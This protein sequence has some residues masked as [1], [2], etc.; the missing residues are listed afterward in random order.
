[1]S[2]TITLSHR[3]MIENNRTNDWEINNKL[4]ERDDIA[5]ISA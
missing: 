2:Y 5:N 4:D 1:M 3:Q